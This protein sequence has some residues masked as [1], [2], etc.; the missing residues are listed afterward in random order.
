MPSGYCMVHD[1]ARKE[2]AQEARRQ[3]RKGQHASQADA[4]ATP[5][6]TAPRELADWVGRIPKTADEVVEVMH[7]T[8]V[9]TMR[10]VC[11]HAVLS[12]TAAVGKQM[13]AAMDG[14][15]KVDVDALAGMSNANLQLLIGG[16][17]E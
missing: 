15:A 14:D 16:A 1:P 5:A 9:A 6:S 17:D 12:A 7:L 3:G 11:T 4:L 2:A 8:W 10:G 13:L